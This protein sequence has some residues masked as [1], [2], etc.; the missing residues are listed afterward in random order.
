MLEEE[1]QTFEHNRQSLLNEAKIK[2]NLA[3]IRIATAE[4]DWRGKMDDLQHALEEETRMRQNLEIEHSSEIE[5]ITQDCQKQVQHLQDLLSQEKENDQL[6][7]LSF[8]KQQLEREITQLQTS[9]ETLQDEFH[10]LNQ[11]IATERL[12]YEKKVS[13]L[14]TKIID[15]ERARDE[16]KSLQAQTRGMVNKAQE[17]WVAK[18]E[19]LQSIKRE[20]E[21]VR[22]AVGDLLARYMGDTELLA[23]ESDL[24]SVIQIFQQNL[25]SFTIR[26]NMTR[27]NLEAMEVDFED[28]S[29][30]YKDLVEEH[31]EW[32]SIASRMAEKMEEYRKNFMFELINHLQLAVDED[33][34][35]ALS[36]KITLSDD[37]AA[38]WNEIIQ[39]SS[40]IDTQKMVIR[41]RKRFKELHDSAKQYKREYKD[42]KGNKDNNR[43]FVCLYILSACF[44]F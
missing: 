14:Q 13:Q 35:N 30:N 22:V 38:I 7:T 33:E 42:L 10:A 3:D 5:T 17:D 15:S 41:L 23:Q 12:D 43:A 31:N 9:L 29:Q 20:H 16:I 18:N 44:F 26:S 28:M 39:I 4:E 2:D 34:I 25:D 40:T 19:E 24:E 37:D 36:K 11:E 32:R 6:D 8:E 1:R 27:Q 21:S